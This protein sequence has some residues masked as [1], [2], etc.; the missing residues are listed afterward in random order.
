MVWEDYIYVKGQDRYFK[1]D[2]ESFL[3]SFKALGFVF[4]SDVDCGTW[5]VFFSW[6]LNF[7]SCGTRD[8]H[9]SSDE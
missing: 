7:G 6:G 1:K 8:M 5:V 3:V 9:F 2:L 4:G